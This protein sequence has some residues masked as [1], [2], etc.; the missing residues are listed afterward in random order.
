MGHTKVMDNQMITVVCD[1][2]VPE[3]PWLRMTTDHHQQGHHNKKE[4]SIV[5][6]GG[7]L[8]TYYDGSNL[9]F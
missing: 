9:P 2:Y 4:E 8:D 5:K 3:R 1:I 6:R 7:H